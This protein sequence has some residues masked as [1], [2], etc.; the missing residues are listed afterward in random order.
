MGLRIKTNIASEMVQR[1]LKEVSGKSQNSLEQL[2]S[3][4]RINKAAD[5]AAGL[6]IATNMEAQ[7]RG[8][9]QAVRNAND[10]TSMV[11][12]A[13][14]GLTE[15]SNILVR[16]RELSVQASSDTVGDQERGFLDLEY[17]QLTEEIDRI[18]KSTTFGDTRLLDGEGS[19]LDFQVGSR[20]DDNN[21]ISFDAGATNATAKGVGVH[22]TSVSRKS[23]AQSAMGDI[24]DAINRVSGYRANL[25]AI[26]SRLQATVANLEVQALNQESAK[27]V[28][29][30]ADV[31]KASASLA[32]SSVIKNSAITTLAQA[33][34]LPS[35]AL[36]LVS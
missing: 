21:R 8:L 14:G 15:I 22:G 12:T 36:R 2:A 35:N 9:R 1:H 3:G 28:I 26:Q 34:N 5:D 11:Q 4:K 32:S 10:G 24:D 33:N 6:A 13:E 23:D 25:G 27:S 17:N 29:M 31:A 16:L 19:V 30:D 7:T 18:A 20:S